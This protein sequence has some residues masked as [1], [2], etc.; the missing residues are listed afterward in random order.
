MGSRDQK[1]R[2]TRPSLRRTGAARS[3]AGITDPISGNSHPWAGLLHGQSVA[4]GAARLGSSACFDC[5]TIQQTVARRACTER[6]TGRARK[7]Q[8]A[9]FQAAAT[10]EDVTILGSGVA[11]NIETRI[12]T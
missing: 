3:D 8:A 4:V 10:R 2:P 11:A 9:I 6:V 5:S 7:C 1:V 12:T